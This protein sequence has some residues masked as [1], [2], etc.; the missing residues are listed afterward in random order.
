MKK[1][2]FIVFEGPDR[3]G[4]STQVRLLSDWLIKNRLKPVLTREPGGARI[5]EA[6]RDILLDA[7]NKISPLTELLLYEAARAQHTADIILPAL[8][9]GKTVISDRFTMATTAYQGYGR[10]LDLKIVET[11]NRIATA[12]LKPDL[13]IVFTMPDN[14]FFRRGKNLKSDRMERQDTAFRLRVNKAYS[15][16]AARRDSFRV[17]A[18]GSVRDI[19]AAITSKL[20]AKFNIIHSTFTRLP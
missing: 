12:G 6:I 14:E 8:K 3:S 20:S 15:V 17:D 10:K 2:L 11:L 18:T 19:H 4:K 13:T 7:K 9:A 5:S 1:G 16:L